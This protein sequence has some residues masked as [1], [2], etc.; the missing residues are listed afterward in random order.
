MMNQHRFVNFNKFT[1]LVG[2]VDN[3]MGCACVGV[4]GIEE[5]SILSAQFCCELKTALKNTKSI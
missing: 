3:G 4:R 1:T 2:N 5:L